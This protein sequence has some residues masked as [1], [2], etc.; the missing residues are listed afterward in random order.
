MNE[1]YSVSR[2]NQYVNDLLSSDPVTRL[3]RVKGEISGYKKYP[4]GHAYFQIKDEDASVRCVLFRGHFSGLSIKPQ[5]GMQ[6][7]V[8]AR[9]NVYVQDGR[10]QL[11]IYDMQHDG[12][13]ALYRQFELLK[14]DLKSQGLFD[15]EKND[16]CF[17]LSFT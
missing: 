12:I 16:K 4:S 3:V 15:E 11:I 14:E 7:V 6:V 10:F 1:I 17:I 13:G 9:A 5:D 2:L 8:S